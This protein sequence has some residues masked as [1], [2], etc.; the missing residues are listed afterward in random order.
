MTQIP[1]FWDSGYFEYKETG[2]WEVDPNKQLSYQ[3]FRER[4]LYFYKAMKDGDLEKMKIYWNLLKTV[5]A[6]IEYDRKEQFKESVQEFNSPL[7]KVRRVVFWLKTPEQEQK[8]RTEHYWRERAAAVSSGI[9]I[10]INNFWWH[11]LSEELKPKSMI[12][13][14]SRQLRDTPFWTYANQIN[15]K[16]QDDAR[17][18]WPVG[19]QIDKVPKAYAVSFI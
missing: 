8:S 2:Y 3:K 13:F 11:E 10:H 15:Q 18:A 14:L 6:D 7:D 9:Q 4:A 1:K 5:K 17:W 12:S 16:K 19:R